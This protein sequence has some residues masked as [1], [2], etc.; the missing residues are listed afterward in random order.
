MKYE[1][2]IEFDSEKGDWK[3]ESLLFEGRVWCFLYFYGQLCI[4]YN[5]DDI[6][7]TAFVYKRG[8]EAVQCGFWGQIFVVMKYNLQNF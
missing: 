5:A 4:E 3:K 1:N 6:Q 7:V 8:P 2:K